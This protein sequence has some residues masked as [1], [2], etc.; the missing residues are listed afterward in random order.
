MKELTCQPFEPLK[1]S[2]LMPFNLFLIPFNFL[3]ETIGLVA[4]PISLSLR[5]FGNLF[6]GELIFILIALLSLDASVTT[7]SFQWMLMFIA[8][9]A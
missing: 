5:L 3:L 1:K 8:S 4:K 9:T 2:I 7:I 6:A